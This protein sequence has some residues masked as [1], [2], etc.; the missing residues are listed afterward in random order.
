MARVLS[1]NVRPHVLRGGNFGQKLQVV[2]GEE[3]HK[4]HRV[5]ADL[6]HPVIMP[7]TKPVR[8]ASL[9]RLSMLVV[10]ATTT[11]MGRHSRSPFFSAVFGLRARDAHNLENFLPAAQLGSLGGSLGDPRRSPTCILPLPKPVLVPV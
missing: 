6:L 1:G 5:Q 9:L 11:E 2:D 10:A 7:L 4:C 3:F 8:T